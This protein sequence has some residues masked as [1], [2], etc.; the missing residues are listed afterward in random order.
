M[1]NLQAIFSV[2]HDGQWLDYV[3]ETVTSLD[4]AASMARELSN[5][6]SCDVRVRVQNWSDVTAPDYC[7]TVE[8]KA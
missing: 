8:H 6:K 1:N 3:R 4:R 2:K 7:Y 5:S